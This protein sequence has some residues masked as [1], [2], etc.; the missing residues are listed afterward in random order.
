M[1]SPVKDF[2]DSELVTEHNALVHSRQTFSV[3]QQRI[4]A[5]AISRIKRTDSGD[6]E[7]E[8]DIKDLVKLGTSSQI[9]SR[10]DEET[11]NLVSKTVTHRSITEDG[12]R[13]VTHWSLISKAEHVEDSGVLKIR[14][15]PDIRE[16]LFNLKGEFSSAVAVEQASCQSIY[17]TRIYRMLVSHWRH[18]KWR[19]SVDQ[20]RYELALEDKYKNFHFFRER[21]LKAAQA[22]AKKNTTMRFTWEEIKAG[23][24]RGSAKKITHLE[25]K[26]TW[27]PGK[28]KMNL[29]DR[30]PSLPLR[31]PK[32]KLSERLT[33]E[34]GLSQEEKKMVLEWLHSRPDQDWPTAEWIHYNLQGYNPL[35]SAGKVIRSKS[36]YFMRQFR[37]TF[38][39]N[40]FPPAKQP[41]PK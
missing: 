22:D 38:K 25:F 27:N 4:L 19:V 13:K 1:N 12:K 10:L 32:Y 9:Y 18:G 16:M 2:T 40:N 3:L 31:E 34:V 41:E 37:D 28:L 6:E 14:F 30:L 5:L 29:D 24:G 8:V 33:K 35:D 17:G 15:D 39:Q 21:V 20:L 11:R 26:F 36:K 7:Y 23:R